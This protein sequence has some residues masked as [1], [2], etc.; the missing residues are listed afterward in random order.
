MRQKSPTTVRGS[1]QRQTAR[2]QVAKVL[3]W[4]T[5]LMPT[6]FSLSSGI[7]LLT[8]MKVTVHHQC[9]CCHT[10]CRV[11]TQITP[12]VQEQIRSVLVAVYYIL[13]LSNTDYYILE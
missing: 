10:Y 9:L 7:M 8:Q 4:V 12:I 3:G 13:I 5:Q 2:G 11:C 1:Y 6:A